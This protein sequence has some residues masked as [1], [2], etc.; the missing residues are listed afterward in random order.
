MEPTPRKPWWRRWFGS[1]SER[2][3]ER[4]LRT[5]GLR[6]LVRNWSCALGEIDLVALTPERV[7]VFVEVRSTESTDED[8]PAASVDHA[9]QRRLTRLAQAFLHRKRLLDRPVRFDVVTVT[10]PPNVR[11]P[12][13]A[14]YPNAFE[15]VG[16][17]QIRF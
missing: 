3:A 6:V 8:R 11:A 5:L 10:W 15:P 9:K 16:V 17:G 2:A 1:R 4:H 14:H 13:I 12:R 7:L